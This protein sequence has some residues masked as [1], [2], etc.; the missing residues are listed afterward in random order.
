ME[1]RQLRPTGDEDSPPHRWIDAFETDPELKNG[2][3]RHARTIR[4]ALRYSLSLQTSQGAP[5]ARGPGLDFQ[6]GP[7]QIVTVGPISVDILR[8]TS[9]RRQA[10]LMPWPA[11]LHPL[12]MNGPPS[13][14][15]R[16]EESRR[17][18][19][20]LVVEV[21]LAAS[22]R[23]GRH[24]P[25]SVL[26]S[27]RSPTPTSACVDSRPGRLGQVVVPGHLADG[28]VTV[29]A[30]LDNLGLEVRGERPAGTGFF[31]SMVSIIGILSGAL[32]LTVEVRQTGRNPKSRAGKR[33]GGLTNT[34]VRMGDR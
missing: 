24:R 31:L 3:G 33:P 8:E 6:V 28:S 20:R 2:L 21:R 25:I 1:P 5:S 27:G 14:G 11:A 29:S 4:G 9:N 13:S 30:V 12:S 18:R 17:S 32:H 23:G 22:W 15:L 19:E 10:R 26:R 34:P 7:N 16:C